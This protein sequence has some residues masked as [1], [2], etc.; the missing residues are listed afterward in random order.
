MLDEF[1]RILFSSFGGVSVV[2]ISLAS[3]L[4]KIWVDKT[5][6]TYKKTS[7]VDLKKAQSELDKALKLLQ[8]ELD[9]DIHIHKVQFEKEFKIYEEIWSNLVDVKKKALPLR[10]TL[11]IVDPS[12]QEEERM[13]RRLGEL[14]SSFNPFFDLVEKHRPFYPSD[15]YS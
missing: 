2:L 4:G 6:Q 8:S 13:R 1:L 3:A 10:P 12:E 15:V 9:K 14:A 7:E 11:D 5:I